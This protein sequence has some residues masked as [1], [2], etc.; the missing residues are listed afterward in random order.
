MLAY[1]ADRW[2]GHIQLQ[3]GLFGGSQGWREQALALALLGRLVMLTVLV[4]IFVAV[5]RGRPRWG[6]WT[7]IGVG[8]LVGIAPPVLV[9]L[10]IALSPG[11]LPFVRINMDTAPLWEGRGVFLLWTAVGLLMIGAAGVLRARGISI[12]GSVPPVAIA[13]GAAL[14]FALTYPVDDLFRRSVIE[15]AERLDAFPMYSLVGIGAR[16]GVMASVFSEGW[17]EQALAVALLGRVVMLAV[18]AAI[19]VGMRRGGPRWAAWALIGIGTLVGI[20]PPVLVGIHIALAPGGLPFVMLN[21]ETAPLWAGRGVYLLWTAVDLLMIGV[22]GVLRARGA[23]FAGSIP[24]VAIAI[25]AALLF[26]LSYPVDELARTSAIELAESA[27]AYPV[28]VV[29][30]IGAR[31]G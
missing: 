28:Y 27:D 11:G 1:L 3:I 21:Q 22:A 25:G 14:L 20:A 29:V 4:A 12:T 8:A 24:P 31:I 26:A 16:V 17:R 2:L 18:L 6:S 30:G 23:S 13:V 7:L 19:F 5:R 9:A 15:L 10:H